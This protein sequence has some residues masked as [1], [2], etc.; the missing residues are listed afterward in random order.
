MNVETY[1]TNGIGHTASIY[2]YI[3]D[4]KNTLHIMKETY[5]VF[6]S[7]RTGDARMRGRHHDSELIVTDSD[8]EYTSRTR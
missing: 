6:I 4:E 5:A 7:P 2:S 3:T 1:A 8:A